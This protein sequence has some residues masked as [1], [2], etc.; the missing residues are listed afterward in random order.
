MWISYKHFIQFIPSTQFTNFADN[1]QTHIYNKGDGTKIIKPLEF[2]LWYSR[3]VFLE[4]FFFCLE[5][6]LNFVVIWGFMK[7][8]KE[9]GEIKFI[10]LFFLFVCLLGRIRFLVRYVS[11]Y[12]FFFVGLCNLFFLFIFLFCNKFWCWLYIY[13]IIGYKIL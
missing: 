5:F 4:L 2:L 8:N 13:N 11:I 3:L 7:W 12:I 9:G 6:F 1:R 10:I